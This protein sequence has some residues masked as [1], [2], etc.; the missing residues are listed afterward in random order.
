MRL[1]W[2]V[3]SRVVHGLGHH[4]DTDVRRGQARTGAA[5][6]RGGPPIGDPWAL[7]APAGK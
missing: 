4:P 1:F 3:T 6:R 5:L 7:A 2:R